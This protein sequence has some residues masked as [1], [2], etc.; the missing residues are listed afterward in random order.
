[1]IQLISIDIKGFKDPSYEKNLKFSTEPISVVFGDNGSGK[2]TLLKILFAVLS[3]NEQILLSENVNH[4]DI[5]YKKAEELKNV[6]IERTEEDKINWSDNLDIYNTSSILFGVHRGVIPDRND[7]GRFDKKR[8]I[9]LV[10]ELYETIRNP[11]YRTRTELDIRFKD[12]IEYLLHKLS[13]TPS[14]NEITEILH[15][16]DDINH[17]SDVRRYPEINERLN[18]IKK[19]LEYYA[20]N[21]TYQNEKS[22]FL[23]RLDS[24]AHLS[25]DFVKIKDIQNAIVNQFNKGQSIV[26]DKIKNAFFETIEK[27]VEID[28]TKE[29][30]HLPDDFE[31]RIQ[32]NKEFILKAIPKENS[33]LTKRIKKYL[34]TGDNSLTDKSKIFRA[35]LLNIIESAEEENPTL[36]AITKLIEIFNEHLYNNKKLI[37]DHEKAFI[38]LSNN[39]FH[40]L[41][42]LSSGERNLLSILTLFLIIGNDRNFLM[43][44]EPEISFNIKWQRDFLPLLSRI[45]SK[46]QIIVASHSPSISHNNSNYLVKLK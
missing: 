37:V 40:E 12:R 14:K 36:E 43:I 13:K 27:A 31:K 10:E 24:Q 1:M 9:M 22:S 3:K 33:S 29:D 45:N 18:M 38:Q 44:D 21:K 25:T 20:F 6:V 7:V 46:A 15:L 16:L 41:S 34:E 28:E 8:L 30:F 4:I 42:E 11:R 26:S 32:E 19:E 5:K 39:K 23:K 35:M 2:T 17:R